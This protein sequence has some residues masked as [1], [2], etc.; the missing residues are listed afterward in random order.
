M[1]GGLDLRHLLLCAPQ[2]F[3]HRIHLY[4]RFQGFKAQEVGAT[5]Q[6]SEF[7]SLNS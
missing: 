4:V 1:V 3:I 5:V 2:P 6:G 7:V